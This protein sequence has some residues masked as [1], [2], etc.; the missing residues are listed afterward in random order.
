MRKMNARG[1]VAPEGRASVKAP[2]IH[3]SYTLMAIA[4]T[5]LRVLEDMR[6]RSQVIDEELAE[7]LHELKEVK[8]Q[9]VEKFYRRGV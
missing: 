4:R 1:A 8:E 6:V 3:L 9:S 7:A 2:E 5:R